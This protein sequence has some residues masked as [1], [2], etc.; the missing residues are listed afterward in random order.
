MRLNNMP[1][2]TAE[3]ALGNLR[4]A[5]PRKGR[6]SDPKNHDVVVPQFPW[7]CLGAFAEQTA[8]C[9]AGGPLDPLCWAAAIHTHQVCNG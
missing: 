4:S 7:A 8:A 6:A 9:M 3:G 2:F 5:G 1:G